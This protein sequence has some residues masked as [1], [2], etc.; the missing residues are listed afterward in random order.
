MAG[1]CQAL[2]A[3]HRQLEVW[4][5]ACPD[6]FE[7]RAASSGGDRPDRGRAFD[8]EPLRTSHH[9]GTGNGF[10]HNEAL[11]KS[12]GALLHRTRL[13]A[14][15]APVSAK[16][17]GL[18]TCAGEPT[19]RC[20]NSMRC[21]RAS[22]MEKPCTAPTSTI[23]VCRQLDL[24]TVIK[25]SQAISGEIVLEKLIEMLCAR[26]LNRPVPSEAC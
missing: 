2:A 26:R 1:A 8:A 18:H 14:N 20:A 12:C 13:R 9:F 6:N 16:R 21:I 25:V 3:H 4:A 22:E 23:G 10:V 7:N 15:R 19:A 11:A 17:P 5:T 24:A